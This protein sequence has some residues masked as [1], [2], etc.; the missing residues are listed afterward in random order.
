MNKGKLTRSLVGFHIIVIS[1]F[2][3]IAVPIPSS[4]VGSHAEFPVERQLRSG[5]EW[6]IDKIQAPISWKLHIYYFFELPIASVYASD[7][8]VPSH[9][10]PFL[11]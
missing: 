8:L 10:W 7:L 5:V 2:S 3:N 9:D 1:R 6:S 4:A 11:V